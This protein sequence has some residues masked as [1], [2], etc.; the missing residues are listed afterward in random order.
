VKYKVTH[1]KET[2]L[3]NNFRTWF[4]KSVVVND[5]GSPKVVFH[6]TVKDFKDNQPKFIPSLRNDIGVHFGSSDQSNYLLSGGDETE[7]DLNSE[8]YR[9]MKVIPCYIR[10]EHP[11]YSE[12]FITWDA[13]SM[14]EFLVEN[15]IL[16]PTMAEKL[17]KMQQVTYYGKEN[18]PANADEIQT[19]IKDTIT[20]A[21][22][23][24][25]YD[26][27]IYH[28]DSEGEGESYMILESNQAKSIF[29]KG[30]WSISN[31]LL[32]E[33]ETEIKKIK[34]F[35]T[36]EGTFSVWDIDSTHSNRADMF[37]VWENKKGW[38]IRNSLIPES[39]RR[40]GIATKFYIKMNNLSLAKTGK[41][42]RSTQER[43]LSNGQRVHELSSDAIALW[44]S[45]VNK[46]L[47]KRLGEKNYTF[48]K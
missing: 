42:L 16:S 23:K 14:A 37:T 28:N 34:S 31:P 4:G 32:H 5:D 9:N 10:I 12:D 1:L 2:E 38:V 18:R 20:R 43:T 15:N 47:A 19:K 8:Y 39:L 3:N 30:T 25:G 35:K 27:I 46:G 45:L 33:N 44:D 24:A 40:K 17:H 21:I 29:N 7:V 11:L 36:E 22:Q 26:G 41:P 6:G 13:S 48:I